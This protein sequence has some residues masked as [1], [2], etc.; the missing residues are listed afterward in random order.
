VVSIDIFV[1]DRQTYIT[2]LVS[3]A[4]DGTQGNSES[5]KASI[6][7]DGRF[8]AFSSRATNL[9]QSDTNVLM[10]VFVAPNLLIP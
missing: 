9:V 5:D 4:S 6:N 8:V 2:E 10:D 3:V 1:H 7:A